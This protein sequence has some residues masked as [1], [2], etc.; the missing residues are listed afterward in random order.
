MG[1]CLEQKFRLESGQKG[2]T[3]IKS[4]MWKS[5]REQDRVGELEAAKL[6]AFMTNYYIIWLTRSHKKI[7]AMAESQ[8]TLTAWHCKKR[9][10]ACVP[11]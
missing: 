9:F 3:Y 2:L 10:P 4:R 5:L 7:L 11:N 1:R 8:G 6:V